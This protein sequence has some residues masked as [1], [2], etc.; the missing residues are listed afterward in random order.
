MVQSVN[1]EGVMSMSPI[2]R[3]LRV[4]VT[5]PLWSGLIWSSIW[6]GAGALVLSLTLAGSS[7]RESELL[8][9][10]FGIHGAASFAGG[11]VAARRSGRKGWYFGT[12]N[13]VLYMLLILLISFLAAETDWSYRVPGL[14]GLTCLAGA[15]GGML[16][17][18][19]GSAH[20]GRKP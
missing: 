20:M 12:A 15:L 13:G 9:W 2:T 14:L 8:P 19:T 7:L 16:G 6:L 3:V 11:F 17:V 18:N 1:I 10:V 5:S 4:R